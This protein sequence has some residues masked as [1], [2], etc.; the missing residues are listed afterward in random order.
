M[1]LR[2]TWLAQGVCAGVVTP[3]R[4]SVTKLADRLQMFVQRMSTLNHG[5]AWAVRWQG[6]CGAES[7]NRA[8]SASQLVLF[9]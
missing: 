5:L 4:L 3:G 6:D 9:L 1:R 2:S 8:E 7:Q